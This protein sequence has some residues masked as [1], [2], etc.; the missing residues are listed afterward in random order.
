[1]KTIIVTSKMI[2]DAV[3]ETL[4]HHCAFCTKSLI[5]A[6]DVIFETEHGEYQL[7]MKLI[8]NDQELCFKT[9]NTYSNAFACIDYF[10]GRVSTRTN[11]ANET[12]EFIA[13]VMLDVQKRLEKMLLDNVVDTDE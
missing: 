5:S 7:T 3:E 11:R 13:A 6:L 8:P 12:H 1:M 10:C 9:K 2:I 4:C